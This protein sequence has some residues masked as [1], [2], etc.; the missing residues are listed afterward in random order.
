MYS[1][2]VTEETFANKVIEASYKQPVVVDFWATWCGPCQVLKP[3]LEKLATEYGG[4][5]LLAKVDSDANQRLSMKYGV[6]GIPNVK[7][8]YQG[9]IINEF[10]GA[11]PESTLREFLNRIIPS[12]ALEAVS[13]ARLAMNNQQLE[14]AAKELETA[15]ELEKDNPDVALAHVELAML[16]GD[17][18]KANQFM[19]LLPAA[20]RLD[21]DVKKLEDQLRLAINSKDLPDEAELLSRIENDPENLQA[22]YDLANWYI[23]NKMYQAAMDRLFEI[24]QKNKNFANDG[25]RKTLLSL[26]SVLENQPEL[27][28]AG[29]RRLAS[30]LN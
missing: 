17:L 19:E 13:R 30:I 15:D 25:A 28:R 29:R 7:A 27:V 1:F 16:Q 18:D 12:P 9:Q 10:S 24:L 8:F 23:A 6:R 26:F 22:R 2:D 5:F 11:L 4:K 21:D 3:I 14:L 20:V